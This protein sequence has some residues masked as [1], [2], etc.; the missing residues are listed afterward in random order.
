MVNGL[1][2]VVCTRQSLIIEEHEEYNARASSD[3]FILQ[4][5]YHKIM[6]ARIYLLVFFLKA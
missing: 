2:A 3:E 5:C 1:C 4:R 6:G